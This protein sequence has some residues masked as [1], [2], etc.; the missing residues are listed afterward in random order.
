MTTE[1]IKLINE[2][3]TLELFI[4][5]LYIGLRR[6]STLN[7]NVFILFDFFLMHIKGMH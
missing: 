3:V 1:T 5:R 4:I 2:P 6:L 7:T